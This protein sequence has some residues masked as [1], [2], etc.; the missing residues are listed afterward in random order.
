MNLLRASNYLGRNCSV[1]TKGTRWFSIPPAVNP[2]NL[3]TLVTTSPSTSS[4]THTTSALLISRIATTPPPGRTKNSTVSSRNYVT[5]TNQL[6]YQSYR[7][8]SYIARTYRYSSTHIP[9]YQSTTFLDATRR[10][11]IDRSPS[12]VSKRLFSLT[13]TVSTKLSKSTSKMDAEHSKSETHTHSHEEHGSLFGHSHAHHQPNELLQTSA[14]SFLTNPAVRITWIGLLVNVAMAISKGIGGVYFHS[15]A[16]VADAIHSVSDMFAD[17]LTLATVNVAA[18]VGSPNKYPFGYGKIETVGSILVSGILLFAGV[19]VGWSSLLQVFE[20]TMPAYLYEYALMI[21]LG[22]SHSHGAHGGVAESHG[23]SHSHGS[24]EI[25]ST[26]SEIPN[27]NAAWLA[28]GSI[29]VKE[30]LFRKTLKVAN[31]VNS[32]V[33]VANAW[34]HRVDSLTSVVALLTVT[35]GVLF[36]VAW[37]DSIGGICVS[38]LIIKAGWGSFKSSWYELVDRGEKPGDE[39]YDK[40]DEIFKEELANNEE[41]ANLSVSELSVVTSGAN[42]NIFAT[43]TTSQSYTLEQLNNIEEHLKRLIHE[44][45]KFVRKIHLSFKKVESKAEDETKETHEC[46]DGNEEHSHKH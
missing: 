45:D 43:L 9:L 42:T 4:R 31:E 28:G 41:F 29:I 26:A 44:D 5:I 18:K 6:P 2:R 7:T 1:Q 36:N 37:L 11:L 22:H 38:I 25:L 15:Q 39:A 33:L 3:T 16:L 23:H 46:S 34:H 13:P 19:S 40:I 12:L 35:G 8:T 32:K 27:I 20:Y 30:L 21:Q 24:E 14:K 10:Q 17:F